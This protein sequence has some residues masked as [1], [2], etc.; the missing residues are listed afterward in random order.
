MKFSYLNMVN[1]AGPVQGN[2]SSY[3]GSWPKVVIKYLKDNHYLQG[4]V[5]EPYSGRS[6]LGTIK[7]D[8]TKSLN[9]DIVGAAQKLPFRDNVFDSAILDPPYNN[10]YSESLYK[11]KAPDIKEGLREAVRCIKPGGYVSMLCFKNM[12]ALKN[13]V[14]IEKVFVNLGP[15]RHI[16]CLNIWSKRGV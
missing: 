6:N 9:P 8:C 15:D 14:S 1:G 2:I 3:P 7:I 16:R 13:M 12:A 4:A 5:L 10:K 11:V